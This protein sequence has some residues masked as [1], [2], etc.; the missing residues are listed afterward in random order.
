LAA[1]VICA[2]GGCD[3][4]EPPASA[5]SS[6]PPSAVAVKEHVRPNP[7]LV[8]EIQALPGFQVELIHAVDAET[9]GS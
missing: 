3:Q 6:P 4:S 5:A 9:E 8:D 1:L 2:L 7:R